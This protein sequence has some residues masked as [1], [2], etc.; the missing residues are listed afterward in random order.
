ML[1]TPGKAVKTQGPEERRADRSTTEDPRAEETPKIPERN[2]QQPIRPTTQ[3][4]NRKQQD[5]MAAESEWAKIP[6]KLPTLTSDNYA[7]WAFDIQIILK[8]WDLWKIVKKEEKH[9][10]APA[11][12]ADNAVKLQY[13]TDVAAYVKKD[14]KAQEIITRSL[15]AIHHDMIR[16]CKFSHNMWDTLNSVYEVTTDTSKLIAQ[17]EFHELKWKPDES[18]MS[19][20]CRLRNTT[21]KLETI[22]SKLDENTV[23]V[24]LVAEAP[25]AFTALKESWEVSLLGGVKLTMSQLLQQLV[26][27]EKQQHLVKDVA[28]KK[29]ED[30]DRLQGAGAAYA[31][32]NKTKKPFEG[33]CFNCG[34]KGHSAARCW[35]PKSDDG[36]NGNQRTPPP[37]RPVRPNLRQGMALAAPARSPGF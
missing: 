12:G 34:K 4:P 9:P 15:D 17:R 22:G 31:V 33:K 37:M 36:N 32:R 5:E 1:G 23:L 18:V 35:A 21:N 29:D 13:Q 11:A 16:S 2:L 25:A 7:R 20:Y 3:K 26:R 14:N 24:K 28:A 8:N 19:F 27:V 6:E 10:A 30:D